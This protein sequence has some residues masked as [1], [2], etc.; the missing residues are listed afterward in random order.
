MKRVAMLMAVAVVF[1]LVPM[2]ARA[3]NHG[4]V[5]AYADYF[6]LQAAHLN[7]IGFGGRLAVNVHPHVALEGE[8]SYDPERAFNFVTSG[9]GGISTGRSG[10]HLLTGLFGPKLQAGTGAFRAFV[11][12]KGGFIDFGGPG[13]GSFTGFSNQIANVLSSTT[14]GAFYPGGGL[15]AYLGPIGLRLD[16][17]D[18]IYFNGGTNNN[19]KI[20][21]GPHIRF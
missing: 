18:F 21:F 19:L 7:M 1:A 13:P 8:V 2:A 14:H 16:V 12:V 10:V 15:E 6:R 4:E 20:T 5:G 17:G 9:I 11:T 3:Q